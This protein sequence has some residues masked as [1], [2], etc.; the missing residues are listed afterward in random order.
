M[1]ATTIYLPTSSQIVPLTC[2]SVSPTK[3]LVAVGSLDGQIIIINSKTRKP[4]LAL[5]GHEKMISSLLFIENGSHLLSSSW[6]GTARMWL[7][8]KKFK[9]S[10]L[11]RHSCDI[12]ALAVDSTISK[13]VAGTRD[14]LVKLFSLKK[15][16][17]IRNLH[18]H[19]RDISGLA[20]YAGDSKLITASWSGKC[21][22]WDLS[23]YEL[24]E[25]IFQ[26]DNRIRSLAISP[27]HTKAALGLHN[28]SVVI[29]DLVNDRKP[30]ILDG[31]TDV[32]SSISF[33]PSDSSLLT[34]S[35][36]TTIQLWANDFSE[37]IHQKLPTGVSGVSWDSKGKK[38]YT[39]EFSGALKCWT[40]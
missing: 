14:G 36:D 4:R 24:V 8:S 35:Y 31:H 13:A 2:V 26:S 3:N 17:C 18:F 37:S 28:G 6:D 27:E 19:R 21:N 32:V 15:L 38:F 9:E 23:S 22:L 7:A 20:F 39:T 25:N 29:L 40:I 10:H 11:L 5:S 1:Q 30:I 33:N 16:K 34:S 12:K